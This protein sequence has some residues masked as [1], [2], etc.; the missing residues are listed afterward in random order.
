MIMFTITFNLQQKWFMRRGFEDFQ[1]SLVLLDHF[2][3]LAENKVNINA[4]VFLEK[5]SLYTY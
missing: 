5:S 1:Q 2:A 4:C 3:N